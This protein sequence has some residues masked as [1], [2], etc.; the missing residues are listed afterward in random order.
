M[1]EKI[2]AYALTTLERVK[3][4]MTLSES[5]FDTLLSREINAVT[6]FI[7]SQTGQRFKETTYTNELYSIEQSGQKYLV[8][9][10]APVASVT[11]I[12]Y[13]VGTPSSKGWTTY[14][15]DDYELVDDGKSGLVRMHAG[16]PCGTNTVRA[17]YVAGYKIAWGATGDAGDATPTHK[18]PAD[19]T[20]LAE[21]LVIRWFKRREAVGKSQEG[22]ESGNVTYKDLLDSE[23]IE[24]INRYKRMPIFV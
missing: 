23:D 19:L 16:L 15:A 18:L 11:S 17:T 20:D 5:G 3:D 9:K 1:P 6:D 21:R 7:E 24:T 2:L 14:G 12:A 4:R 22:F 8:L 10:H 13:G